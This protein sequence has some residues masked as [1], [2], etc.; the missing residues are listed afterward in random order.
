MDALVESFSGVRGIYGESLT[1][2]HA[3][4]YA[5]AFLHWLH[6]DQR[7]QNPVIIIARD[8]RPSG[9]ALRDV[10]V[11]VLRGAGVQIVDIGISSTPATENAVR[12]FQADAGIMLTA[13]HNPPEYNGWKLLR[14]DGAIV[15]A[16]D[17]QEII[18]Y[19]RDEV[20][21]PETAGGSVVERADENIDAYVSFV[22][23]I[24]GDDAL[25]AMQNAHIKLL[26]DCAGGAIIP[27]IKKA[28]EKAGIDAVYVNDELGVFNRAIEPT[29][30]SLAPLVPRIGESG[31]LFAV[32]FDAD[33]DRAE[34]VLPSGEIVSGQ[35][36]LA[37]AVDE[38]LSS[39]D[40]PESQTVVVNDA[41][42]DLVHEIAKKHNAQIHEV[43]TGEV[44]VV[45]EMQKHQ[46]LVGGEGS[47]GGSII[48]PQTC[49]DGLL[50]C[51]IIVRHIVKNGTTLE[52]VL[53][54]YPRFY[55]LNQ[56]VKTRP[57]P[58]FRNLLESVFSA[59]SSVVALQ[60][61]GDETGGLKVRYKDGWVWFRRSKTEPGL[62]RVYA[63]SPDEIRARA[64]LDQ[65]V[66]T[67]LTVGS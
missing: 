59:D 18:S 19:A 60:K 3:R 53:Q 66:T 57:K 47:S 14:A 36:A 21:M 4:Q 64:L 40:N 42:S 23:S 10:F 8:T 56:K 61:T 20:T 63:E 17:A 31:A 46:S 51:L 6:A 9:K 16:G 25:K 58:N 7:I 13:S 52:R 33:A 38:I 34:F 65:A 54:N 1:D 2:R 49:R 41:T 62:V 35:H 50:S 22:A 55:T 32:G 15:G 67:L 5:H 44:N 45:D 37:V 28:V 26:F 43:E 29:A 24:V 11:Q 27:C 30:Q 39:T 12:H 48:S